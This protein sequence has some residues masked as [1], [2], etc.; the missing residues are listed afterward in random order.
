M[1]TIFGFDQGHIFSMFTIRGFGGCN[2]G[3]LTLYGT[4]LIIVSSC[5]VGDYLT[6]ITIGQ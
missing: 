3:F 6:L 4:L 1:M 2:G 5:R